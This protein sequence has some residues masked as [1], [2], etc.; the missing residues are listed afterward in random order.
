M[1]AGGKIPFL[2]HNL[3]LFIKCPC[4]YEIPPLCSGLQYKIVYVII[5]Y[6]FHLYNKYI[7]YFYFSPRYETSNRENCRTCYW[8]C[9]SA[10]EAVSACRYSESPLR[11]SMSLKTALL[12]F[13]FSSVHMTNHFALWPFAD[14]GE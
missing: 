6:T 12:M 5:S 10:S 4:H 11:T 7:L 13:L 3:L 9:S 1:A 2:F 8:F 14:F